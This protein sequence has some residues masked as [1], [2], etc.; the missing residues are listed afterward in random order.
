MRRAPNF[1]VSGW[2][3]ERQSSDHWDEKAQCAARRDLPWAGDNAPAAPQHLEMHGICS[4]CPVKLQCALSGTEGANGGFYAG[5]WLPW[6]TEYK[7]GKD[8]RRSALARLRRFI[9]D[10]AVTAA[11]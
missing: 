2:H 4:T 8:E 7:K 10:Q 5:V 6:P 11:S 9:M 3:R 1:R